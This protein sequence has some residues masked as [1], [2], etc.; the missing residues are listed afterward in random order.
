MALE[1]AFIGYN[2]AQTNTYFV[3]F[4]A[5]NA[6]Q[7][8]RFDRRGGVIILK[9]GTRI[10]KVTPAPGFLKGRRFDQVILAD[11]RRMEILERRA[12]ELWALLLCCE[13]SDVPP[14]FW[15]QTYDLD[16]EVPDENL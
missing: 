2:E 14:D 15:F 1:I 4:A 10:T 7:V 12:P 5:V 3:D 13:R 9:D 8:R 11:D 16:A 6:D